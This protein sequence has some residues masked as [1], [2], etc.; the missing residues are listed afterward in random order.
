MGYKPNRKPPAKEKVSEFRDPRTNISTEN[1]MEL[2]RRL[3]RA[4]AQGIHNAPGE[5]KKKRHG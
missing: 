4:G 3:L 2:F 5:P 1:H